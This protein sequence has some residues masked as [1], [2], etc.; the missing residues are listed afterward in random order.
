MHSDGDLASAASGA[1]AA[2][3]RLL[4]DASIHDRLLDG[5]FLTEPLQ[6]VVPLELL[7]LNRSVLIQELINREVASSNSDLDALLLDFNGDSLGS[8]LI[9]A[10]GFPH[11]HDLEL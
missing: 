8:K 6:R 1:V 3:R 11:E 5:N 4:S 7:Q 9:H 10:L 2:D